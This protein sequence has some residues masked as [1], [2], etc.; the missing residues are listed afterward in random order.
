MRAD[1]TKVP[2]GAQLD[3]VLPPSIA[4]AWHANKSMYAKKAWKALGPGTP[5]RGARSGA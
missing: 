3:A 1:A 2:A 4:R 5:S